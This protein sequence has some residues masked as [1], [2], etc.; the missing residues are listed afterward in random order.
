MKKV[1]HL[2]QTLQRRAKELHDIEQERQVL[3]EQLYSDISPFCILPPKPPHQVAD[4]GNEVAYITAKLKELK[5]ANENSLSYLYISGNPGSGKS[6]L[7]G[8]VARRFFN[9]ANEVPCTTSFVMTI[10]AESPDTLLESY[11]SFARHLKCPEYAITN[12]LNAKDLKIDKKITNLKTLTTKKIELY[13]SWLLVV[14]NVTDI[15]RVHAYFPNPGNDQWIRGQLL[16][17]TKDTLAIPLTSPCTQHISVSKG[18]DPRDASFLLSMLSGIADSEMEK[19]VAHAM[20]YQPLALAGAATY[21]R[22]VRQ[23]KLSLNFGWRDYLK[24][25]EKGQREVTEYALAETNPSYQKSMTAAI[26][27]AVENLMTSS[28]VLDH[29]FSFLSLCSSQSLNLKILID[30]ILNVDEEIQDEEL[31]SM[32]IQRC[33]LLLLEKEGTSVCIRVHQ[34]VHDVIHTVTKHYPLDKQFMVVFGAVRSFFYFIGGEISH[35]WDDLGSLV[36]S[37]HTLPHLK[38]LVTKIE[39]LFSK[40]GISEVLQGNKAIVRD[41]V[42]MFK[43][44]G[45]VCQRRCEFSAAK[46]YSQLLLESI[47]RGGINDKVSLADAYVAISSVCQDL[48]DLHQAKKYCERELEIRLKEQG[49]EH[50]K[51]ASCYNNLG[52]V[53]RELGD[54]QRAKEYHGRCLAIR[55]K[56]KGSEHVMTATAYEHLGI[57]HDSLG[58]LQEAK[59]YHNRALA[60]RLE[61]LGPEHVDVAV[62]YEGLGMLYCKLGE[63][64]LAKE[65]HERALA[66]RLNQQGPDHVDVATTYNALG[67]VHDGLDNLE[68]AKEYHDRALA[69]RLKRQGPEHPDVALNCDLLTEIHHD[70]GDSDKEKEYS[71]RAMAI[72][73][74]KQG[75]S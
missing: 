56:T 18:M 63:L 44:L 58:D 45:K 70:L 54:L 13:T 3:E 39:H 14:D 17:T 36:N 35:Y 33:S 12:T 34:V 22:Q 11:V 71:D 40:Q 25:I 5:R 20:D 72:R 74:K 32:R 31:I 57:L 26:T 8:L 30:Y 6:Q 46:K 41:S 4:R 2:K 48:G 1:D 37:K 69:I 60:I 47:Q 27:L 62:C 9:E 23:G 75:P 61:T 7:A 10:N 24:K 29:T 51:V 50:D 49:P 28:K 65:Y 42:L 19:E 43:V 55:L 53:F 38:L 16:I 68:G 59:E 15:S 64:E 52:T 66:I 73:L 21:V 67:I